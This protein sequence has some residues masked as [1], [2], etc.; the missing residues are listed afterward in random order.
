MFTIQPK[1]SRYRKST[2]ASVVV[3][4]EPRGTAKWT[5]EKTSVLVA[6]LREAVSPAESSSVSSTDPDYAAHVN[7][8]TA[9]KDYRLKAGRI[10]DD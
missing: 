6:A 2:E 4:S 5:H 7:G 1:M 10:D 8:G 9:L 3:N